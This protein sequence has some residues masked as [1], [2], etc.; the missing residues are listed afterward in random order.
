MNDKMNDKQI[1]QIIMEIYRRMFKEAEPSGDIDKI[2]KSGEGQEPN[3]FM[4][5]YLCEERQKKIIEEV[6]KK[7]K[8]EKRDIQKF[9]ATC[10][11]GSSPTAQRE[12]MLRERR[13]K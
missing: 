5:Y 8:C 4:K 9:H 7:N 13:S 12:V 2:I 6:C 11:L 10:A 3:F 1:E